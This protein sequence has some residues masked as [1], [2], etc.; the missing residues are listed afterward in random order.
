MRTRL[1]G[2]QGD[3]KLTRIDA[4]A[5]GGI[6]MKT[7]TPILQAIGYGIQAPN[8]H[9]T[10]AWKFEL[11]SDSEAL[12]YIDERRLLLVTDPPARQI[13]IG[14]GCAIE[15]LAVGMSTL[16]YATDVDLLPDGPYGFPEIGQ[17][18]VA[19]IGLRRSDSL[20]GDDLAAFIG[21]RQTN[22]KP[23]T[24]PALS[25][26]EAA[27]IRAQAG[28][29]DVEILTLDRPADMRPL[30]DIFYRAT[31]IELTTPHLYE[32]TRIWFR[33]NERQRRAHRDGLS[34][35]QAGLDGLRRRF[36]EWSLRNGD[37]ERWFSP[38]SIG[39]LLETYH[40]GLESARG[41][42]LLKTER[43]DQLAW[44]QAGRSFA[45]VGLTLAQLGLTSHPYSQVLQEYPEMADLQAEFNALLAVRE[46]SKV[47]MAVRVGRA[48]RAYKAQRR[49]P[50]DY[51]VASEARAA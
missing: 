49:E 42:V 18:P 25:V 46:P 22:R 26:D 45:R 23:Y 36:V 44:L 15:T 20:R 12:L 8:P 1:G 10:Q 43:N 37:P 7:E 31:E 39:P 41:L 35:A 19:R 33:F 32:E 11:V 24:G 38:K 29:D 30:L 14:A 17:K 34:V 48:E 13:H 40:R 28:S 50:R 4:A 21:Q 16:G 6:P 5:K 51:I 2:R 9:N 27:S 47:Q 3:E